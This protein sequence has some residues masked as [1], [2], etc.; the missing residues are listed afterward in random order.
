M[1]YPITIQSGIQPGQEVW[2]GI[3][4][5][6]ITAPDEPGI[7][8]FQEIVREDESGNLIHVDFVFIAM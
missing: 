6:Y 3:P 8:E 5:Q 1:P 7:Y 4:G 2:T